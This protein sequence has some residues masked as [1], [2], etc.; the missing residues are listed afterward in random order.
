MA[1]YW[2]PVPDAPR[3]PEFTPRD[4]RLMREALALA[5]RGRGHVEPNPM[6]GALIVRE[7]AVVGRGW[8][9][10]FG[11]PHAEVEAL[12]SLSDPTLAR[13]AT[14]YV[15]LEPCCHDGKTPPCAQAIIASGIVQV[16]A[17]MADPFPKVAGGG[18]AALRAAGIAVRHGLEETAARLLNAGYLKR[19]LIGRP[20][21]TAKWAMTLDGKTA[22]ATGDSRWISNPRSRARVHQLRGR[23][24]AILVG[25]GTALADDPLLTVRPPGPR[26]PARIVLDSQARL[27]L[28]SQL[29]RSIDHAPLWLVHRPDAPADR[30]EAL[31]RAGARLFAPP[32]E[33]AESPHHDSGVPIAPLLDELGREGMTPLLVEGG[34]RV[35]GAFFAAGAIDALE[36]Y[37]APRV[38]GGAATFAPLLGQGRSLMAQAA[39]LIESRAEN[40]E[41][42]LRLTGRFAHSWLGETEPPAFP[43]SG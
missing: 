16:V 3:S 10:R 36:V 34:G 38:I 25:I 32:M 35:A 17:A 13:G 20:Y 9:R 43:A 4:Q 26:V 22:A 2:N 19:V 15:T 18:F 40:L 29:V 33:G 8:H 6:V 11:G 28:S 24:D 23:M 12:R 5:E 31:E 37:L 41:G 7:G 27:P 21:V 42:D 1:L 14:M 30:L 39:R